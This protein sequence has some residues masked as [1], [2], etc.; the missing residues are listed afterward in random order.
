MSSAH[1]SGETMAGTRTRLD[2]AALKLTMEML[3]VDVWAD[4]SKPGVSARPTVAIRYTGNASAADDLST[5]GPVNGIINYPDHIQPLW[6]RNRGT[7]T[8]TTCHNVPA[9]LDLSGTTGGSGRIVSYDELMLGDPVL[10]PVTGLPKTRIEEGVV[11]IERGP[12]LVDT[13]ASEGEALGLARKSR[14]V[15]ILFGQSLMAGSAARTA[16]PN[17]PVSAPN[18]ATILN[19]AEKRLIA[20]WID[21]G[22]KYYND[23]FDANSGVRQV[24]GL[25]QATFEAQVFPILRTTCAA[26]CHQAIGSSASATPA[27]TSFRNNRFVLTGDPEGDYNVTLT[28]ISD[29]CKPSTNA[30]LKKPSTAPHPVGALVGN[31]PIPSTLPVLPAGSASYNTISRWIAGGC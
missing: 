12:A 17:P 27:G 23:P 4:T 2:P 19:R 31:P 28:M 5:K 21:L 22:S 14:L 30:L 7:S 24:T 13:A 10:D 11:V 25:S 26:S 9:K 1:Q 18:H 29:T 20:E 6:T 16:H 8:C 3:S 15:E